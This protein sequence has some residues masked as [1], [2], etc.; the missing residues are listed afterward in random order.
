MKFE[1]DGCLEPYMAGCL[2]VAFGSVDHAMHEAETVESY[3]AGEEHIE[4][5]QLGEA[6]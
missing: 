5:F 6:L 1:F 4:N 2:E 3:S